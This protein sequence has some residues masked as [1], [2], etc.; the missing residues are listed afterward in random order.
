MK[1]EKAIY[2]G[3]EFEVENFPASAII[4]STLKDF[5]QKEQYSYAVFIAMVPDKF[6]E[7]GHPTPD[8]YDYLNTV[9]K[10]LIAYLESETRTVHVGHTTI[11]RARQIIFY[12]QDRELVE[13]YLDYYLPTTERESGF[14]IENDP[15]WSNVSAFYE[16]L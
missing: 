1:S 14:E 15:E 4:N 3:F 2:T 11:Y 6:D 10:E 9:E 8:E 16:L 5:E 13:S 7:V 12:T